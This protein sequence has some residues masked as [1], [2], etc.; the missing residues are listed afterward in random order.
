[1]LLLSVVLATLLFAAPAS[2]N[3][4]GSIIVIVDIALSHGGRPARNSVEF[5]SVVM[6][7]S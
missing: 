2:T 4:V 3:L 6:P 5:R 7:F 1:V